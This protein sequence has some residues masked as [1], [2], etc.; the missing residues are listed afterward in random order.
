VVTPETRGTA[1]RI[2]AMR[3][4]LGL[5]PL[6]VEEVPMALAADGERISA[7]RIRKG[8]IDLEGRLLRA[9]IAVGS[10]NPAKVKAVKAAAR[11]A[12]PQAAVKGFAV[13]SGVA[14]QPFD[15]DAV[16]GAQERAR[17]AMQRWPE[18]Q[19]GVGIE[20][21][22][23]YVPEAQQHVDVTWCAV[24]DRAG[25]FT[26][27]HSPGFTY[28][29]AVVERA[30]QGEAV[31]DIMAEVSGVKGIGRK[32]GAVGFLTRGALDRAELTRSAVL[33]ALAPRLRP[34]LHGL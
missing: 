30:K 27:G 23:S 14:E 34:E 11:D 29:Q 21:G 26:Y 7:T 20:A 12:F 9:R 3:K 1:G 24:M 6:R 22:L 13:R 16:K 10:D 25:R 18:A 8:D 32:Q 17:L 2:N 5:A 28:P 4:D 15:G 19:L 31:G 33:L